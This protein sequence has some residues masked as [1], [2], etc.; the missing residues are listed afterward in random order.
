LKNRDALLALLWI[1]IGLAVMVVSHRMSLGSLHTPGPGLLPF[2]LGSLLIVVSLPILIGPL[3]LSK[4]TAPGSPTAG[5]WEGVELKNVLIIIIS[6][7]AYALLLERLGFILAA[8]LFLFVLFMAF[9]S[10][11]WF[12]AL[13]VS[14]LTIFVIYL[15]FIVVLRVELPS[16]LLRIW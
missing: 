15:L 14:S 5:I 7:V 13:G 1:T 6:L 11:R 8:F 3:L 9:D 2:L 12:F 4:R 10:H 16:G